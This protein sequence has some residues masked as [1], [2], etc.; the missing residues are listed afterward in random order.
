MKTKEESIKN[1]HL[2]GIYSIT[3]NDGKRY[4]GSTQKSFQSRLK[5][6]FE[7]LRS[8]N[9][10]NPHLQNSYNKNRCDHFIFEILEIL[11]DDFQM[12]EKY[13]IEFYDSGN[14]EKGYNVWTNPL[15][16]PSSSI[17]SR[18]KISN[19]LKRKFK[20]GEIS[21]NSGNWLK[22]KEPWNKGKK[23]KNTDHLKVKKG[24]GRRCKDN[25]NPSP[26]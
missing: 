5:T 16:A 19:T 22:G 8:D 20:S 6:H 15:I 10:M 7:K 12:R 13:W 18:T 24:S 26:Q 23:Y 1:L 2:K 21:L 4:I 11:E 14:R 17:E 9:H 25:N 3:S